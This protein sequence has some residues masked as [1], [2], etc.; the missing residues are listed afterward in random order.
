MMLWIA[1]V[2]FLIRLVVTAL[3]ND[4]EK[5]TS[6]KRGVPHYVTRE[7][8]DDTH[9]PIPAF[10]DPWLHRHIGPNVRE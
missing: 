9:G 2:A 5:S 4:E 7:E 3:V 10:Y 8:L 1:A 6:Q